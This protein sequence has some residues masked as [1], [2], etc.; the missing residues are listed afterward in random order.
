M[1]Q[2]QEIEEKGTAAVKRMRV[3]NLQNGLPFMINIKGLPAKQC[4]LEYPNGSI[5]LVTTEKSAIDFT[6]IRTL[7][8]NEGNEL[9]KKYNLPL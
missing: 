6:L 1:I 4:Y 8:K 5:S 9:R 2:M 7:S 3:K